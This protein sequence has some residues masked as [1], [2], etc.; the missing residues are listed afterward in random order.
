[1]YLL[2]TNIKQSYASF[3]KLSD[4]FCSQLR[5]R[6][7]WINCHNIPCVNMSINKV[8]PTTSQTNI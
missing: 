8:G 7:C 3:T 2:Y 1:M 6:L 5:F 4:C